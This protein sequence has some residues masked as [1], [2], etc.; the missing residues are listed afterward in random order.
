MEYINRKLIWLL[1]LSLLLNSCSARP[2][3]TRVI[4]EPEPPRQVEE[5]S[6]QPIERDDGVFQTGV[7][8]W[9]GEGDG[10]NGKRTANGEVYDMDKLTAAHKTL[11]FHTLVEVKNT[12][13]GNTVLVRINDRGPF[14]K[15]RIIDLSRN[16]AEQLGM[17][18]TGT[19]PVQLRIV[20]PGAET[21]ARPSP[22]PS[23]PA[24]EATQLPGGDVNYC[25]QVGAFSSMKNA[26]RMLRQVLEVLPGGFAFKI[27]FQDGLYKLFSNNLESRQAAEILKNRLLEAGIDSFIRASGGQEPF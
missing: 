15:G 5:I 22:Q 2:G 13:N 26:K 6:L 7:A 8:S 11:P 17:K 23:P 16:A 4:S 12:E 24:Y 27:Q 10:F 9:Y 19:A 3:K 1:L 25:I 14:L 20:K 18:E 21:T